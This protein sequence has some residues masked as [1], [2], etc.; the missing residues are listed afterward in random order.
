MVI[1]KVGYDVIRIK[2]FVSCF[3]VV[4]YGVYIDFFLSYWIKYKDYYIVIK[5]W[6]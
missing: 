1:F 3:V 6:F 5:M 2:K 4:V